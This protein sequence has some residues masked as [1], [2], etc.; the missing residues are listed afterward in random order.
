MVDRI[1][2]YFKRNV[3]WI[4]MTIFFVWPLYCHIFCEQAK[5]I[6]LSTYT[7]NSIS[8]E[9]LVCCVHLLCER[10]YNYFT[11]FFTGSTGFIR[12]DKNAYIVIFSNKTR[13]P[14]ENRQNE[15]GCGHF[16]NCFQLIE[17]SF[18]QQIA[19]FRQN[20]VMG[21]NVSQYF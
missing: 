15:I 2:F 11:Q 20:N 10:L 3:L 14:Q 8:L 7:C 13:L 5:N 1:I 19:S 6:V 9:V 21:M 4:G 16:K 12:K 17:S 18:Q